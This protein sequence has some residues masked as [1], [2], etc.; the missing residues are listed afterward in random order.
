MAVKRASKT[1][2]LKVGHSDLMKAFLLVVLTVAVK[3]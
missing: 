1:V 3:D 2:G